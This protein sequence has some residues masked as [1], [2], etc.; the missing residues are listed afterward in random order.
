MATTEINLTG[1][2]GLSARHYEGTPQLTYNAGDGELAGGVYNPFKKYGYLSPANVSLTNCNGTINNRNICTEYDP[3]YRFLFFAGGNELLMFDGPEETAFFS[4]LTID[5]DR[6]FL[7]LELYEVADSRILAYVTDTSD[8]GDGMAVGFLV[9]DA[10]AGIRIMD[11]N[12]V[13]SGFPYTY[14]T[15]GNSDTNEKLAQRFY[16]GDVSVYRQGINVIRLRLAKH[17]SGTDYSIRAGIQRGTPTT[18][19]GTYIESTTY[20]SNR[21]T[22]T[23]DSANEDGEDIIFTLN[24]TIELEDDNPY[25]I[26]VEPTDIGDMTGTNSFVWYRT[27]L[28][29]TFYEAGEAYA[30]NGSAWVVA[31]T[32]ESGDSETFDCSLMLNQ[33]DTWFPEK[34]AQFTHSVEILNTTDLNAPTQ[35]WID[36]HSIYWNDGHIIVAWE[37]LGNDGYVQ[38]LAYTD[39]GVSSW[40]G[41]ALEFDTAR[42]SKMRMAKLSSTHFVMVWVNANI[43]EM[44]A[45]VF[46]VNSSTYAITAV[47][48]PV[49]IA[50]DGRVPD[51]AVID[52]SNALVTYTEEVSGDG[53]ATII[54]IDGSYA[55]TT[56]AASY[57]FED[58][59]TGDERAPIE[60]LDTT[61]AFVAWRGTDGDGFC[62]V[63]TLNTSTPAITASGA[64]YEFDTTSAAELDTL[65]LDSTH[66]L[67]SYQSSGYSAV[68]KVVEINGSYTI[69]DSS[70]KNTLSANSS[71]SD[72]NTI[73]VAH[74]GGNVYAQVTKDRTTDYLILTLFEIDDTTHETTKRSASTVLLANDIDYQYIVGDLSS[75]K[76]IIIYKNDT[77]DDA[78]AMTVKLTK[79][80]SQDNF[81]IKEGQSSFL[82]KSDNGILYWFVGEDVHSID[83]SVTGA[84]A[85]VFNRS[86]LR[87][88]QYTRI[89]DAIDSR[90]FMNIAINSQ[91]PG[92]D[93]GYKFSAKTCGVFVWDRQSTVISSRDFYALEGAK[94]IRKMFKTRNGEVMLIVTAN[95]GN[96]ELRKLT[97]T[98]AVTVAKF[99]N[100]GYPA[101]TDSFTYIDDM[102]AWIGENGFVYAWGAVELG[103]P[104][105][106]HKIGFLELSGVMIATH[107]GTLAT[108]YP[109][110]VYLAWNQGGL[111]P[112]ISKW[113]PSGEGTLDLVVQKAYVGNV[114]S[115]VKLLPPLSTVNH[116]NLFSLPIAT[117][118]STT[119]GTLKIY[120]NQS[121]TPWASK[122]IT[123]KDLAKGVKYIPVGKSFINSVQVEIEWSTAETLGN[124]TWC[125]VFAQIDYTPTKTINR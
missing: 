24:N 116:I 111:T 105:G 123:K 62:R 76:A 77:L 68:V 46:A 54:A 14:E 94:E 90:G 104:E 80:I 85:G 112:K 99:E 40:V 88:P 25:W 15:I 109:T 45:Q 107:K 29:N 37:G 50:S 22:M 64:E 108:N 115:P 71:G 27:D 120:F 1:I 56:T 100:T 110:G 97:N 34:G 8:I 31:T 55:I 78:Y 12:V 124:D 92:T 33:T 93:P 7:D 84:N 91:N 63:L 57:E 38:T 23:V 106:L 89:V 47:G 114:Y 11:L 96:S 75:G 9:T 70:S 87:F 10:T 48:S 39:A 41:T 121:S 36:N 4:L 49:N 102:A 59:T 17:G 103:N 6:D 82:R 95:S 98:G 67:L 42:A 16:R 113:Y 122:T 2:G 18:P 26:V 72:A 28:D 61:H 117:S 60:L 35:I 79:D 118:D 21:L 20:A 119:V 101:Y 3:F 13:E 32:G 65:M 53:F 74:M 69:T 30:Y 58:D 73:T 5:T 125:P 52:S 43:D 86:I 19:D 66:I 51:I 83:G 44:L 81:Y